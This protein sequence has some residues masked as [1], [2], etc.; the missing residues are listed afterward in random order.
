MATKKQ[1]AGS[2]IVPTYPRHTLEQAL[3]IP[4][5]IL[6]QNAGQPCTDQESATY[7][8]V[9]YNKGKYVVELNSCIKYGLLERPQDGTVALTL[10]ARRI[11]RPQSESDALHGLREAVMKAPEISAVYS[12]YLPRRTPPNRDILR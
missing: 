1:S 10:L 11:L 6:E 5:G 9:I 3:R 4:K 2:K 7:S 8:G 12:H